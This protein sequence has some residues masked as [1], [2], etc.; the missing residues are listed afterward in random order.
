MLMLNVPATVG[1]MVLAEPIVRVLLEHGRFTPADTLATAAALQFYAIGL[2]GYSVVRIV[3]PIFYA[4][5]RNR[6]PV[7][8]SVVVVLVNAVLNYLLVHTS[9]RVPR[10][11][12]G[13][14][15]RRADQRRDAARSPARRTCMG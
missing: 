1:L 10:T 6:T 11:G 15:D 8:V 2:V 3:S 7:I 4:L 9:V 14:V 12:V 13:H 5:G